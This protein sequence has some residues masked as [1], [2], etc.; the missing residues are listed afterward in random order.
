MELTLLISLITYGLV[1]ASYCALLA[2][3]FSVIYRAA[4]FFNFAHAIVFTLGPYLALMFSLNLGWSRF[5]SYSTAILLCSVIGCLIQL[6]ILGPLARRGAPS[7]VLLL[8]SL[9][10]YIVLQNV[11]SAIFGDETRLLQSG[12]VGAGIDIRGIRF[13]SHH[14]ISVGVSAAVLGMAFGLWRGTRIGRTIRAV[15]S[16]SALAEITGVPRDRIIMLIFAAASAT[17]ATAGILVGLDLGLTPT[18]GMKV[19]MMAAVAVIVG[20]VGSIPGVGLGSL[21]LGVAQ[22]LAIWRV[23]SRWQD[24]IAFAILLLF[25]VF[26]PQ[27]FLGQPLKETAV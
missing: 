9:G 10:V 5:A 16:D 26:R 3:G 20:G 24:T 21:L 1:T 25:L 4:G 15:C 12:P 27:G 14:V 18:M 6:C 11:L 22:Y 2:L 23:D 19:L 8:A 17:A 13:S 7:L